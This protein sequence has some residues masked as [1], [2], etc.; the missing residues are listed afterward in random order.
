MG[1][2]SS[3][4]SAHR[5]GTLLK[6]TET[7]I[8]FIGFNKCGSRSFAQ[9]C[10][11]AGFDAYHG[12]N[13]DPL[14]LLIPINLALGRKCLDGFESY[15]AFSDSMN[16]SKSFRELDRDYPNG[17]KYV[18]NTRNVTN[19]LVSRLNHG[20]GA[21]VEFMNFMNKKNLEWQEWVELWREEFLEHE[22]QVM[23]YFRGREDIFLRYDIE[24][25]DL[26]K[27]KNFI[28][29]HLFSDQD[30]L[31]HKGRTG[32]VFFAADAD[33]IFQTATP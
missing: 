27:F 1:P 23:D 25:D 8:F 16:L 31:P 33:R 29:P 9:L 12:G 6:M 18:L 21:Y 30:E 28:G 26:S 32:K 22:R 19:W 10:Q 7:R 15:K 13:F 2:P 24:T 4:G 3:I 17:S 5:L 11:R 20:N 14:S